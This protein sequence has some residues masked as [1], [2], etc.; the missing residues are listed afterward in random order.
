MS[1]TSDRAG[2][3]SLQVIA[4]GTTRF[5][6]TAKDHVEA[7]RT[8]PCPTC[9]RPSLSFFLQGPVLPVEMAGDYTLTFIG[10]TCSDIPADV[11]TRTYAVT[12]TSSPSAIYPPN[13][14]F[15]V[16]FD[17]GALL[18][19]LAWRDSFYLNVDGRYISWVLG[20][21]HGQPGVVEQIG[22]GQTIAFGGSGGGTVTGSTIA[23]SF[24]GFIDYCALPPEIVSALDATGRYVCPPGGS[25]AH[26][27]CASAQHRLTLTPR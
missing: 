25:T 21:L 8:L 6:A 5:R 24:D 4:D 16:T 22:R 17:S 7:T 14:L 12:V 23:F 15:K 1:A 10:D 27:Q 13:T 11:R 9:L 3:F 20:D 2:A 18:E 19:G 26:V